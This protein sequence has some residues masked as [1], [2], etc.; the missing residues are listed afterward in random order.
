MNKQ[1]KVDPPEY[2]AQVRDLW[3]SFGGVPVLKGVSIDLKPGEIHALAGGNGAG[4]STLMKVINGVIQ[5]DAGEIL[6]GGRKVRNLSPKQAHE[7]GIC[8]VP[9]EPQLF[10]NLSVRENLTLALDGVKTDKK[11]IAETLRAI[12]PHISLDTVAGD[13]SISDQQIIEIVRG[14]LS[15]AQVL[16]VDEPTAALTVSET[17]KLF[18]HLRSLSSRGVGIF[19]ITHRL[20]EIFELCHRV[21][22]L[23]DGEV[24]LQ[25]DVVET[26]VSEIV[27]EM[28]P[29]ADTTIVCRALTRAEADV[30]PVLL[31]D[32]LTGQGFRDVTFAVN[33]GEI[34]G[35]AGVVGSGRTE[36][37]ETIYGIRPGEGRVVVAGKEC[38]S[39]SPRIM[40]SNGLSYVAEDRH[41]NGVFLTGDITANTTSTV[42]DSLAS[43]GLVSRKKELSFAQ[44][45]TDRLSLQPGP[46]SRLV[47]CLSGGN[48]QKV[49]LAKSLANHPRVLILDEPS[50]GVDV[51]ARAD[52]YRLIGELAEA[53]TA[54]VVISSD[55]EEIAEVASRVLI[56]RGG[57]VT[58]ELLGDDISLS[59]V[60]DYSFGLE[61]EK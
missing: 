25:K 46:M 21:T 58:D 6:I 43:G 48:Q 39:R 3:K 4:K 15:D 50:R 10:P 32:G 51:G 52:L 42:V 24:A 17:E 37:A 29:S 59:K 60:R 28:I 30:E 53:G 34:V 47:S 2:A 36:V 27:S 40:L 54:V 1:L 11:A 19:Y 22:V 7:N 49:S 13:L 9:Q 23:R 33:P 45:L 44:E 55:F 57:S 12:A 26:S 61:G 14:V 18:G 56:M 38:P 41:L 8:M 35:L 5:A 20:N 16:V 31:V